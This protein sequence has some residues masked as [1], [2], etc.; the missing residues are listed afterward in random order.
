VATKLDFKGTKPKTSGRSLLAKS[1]N[2]VLN[3][4]VLRA[5]KG[6]NRTTLGGTKGTGHAKRARPLAP[7]ATYHIVLRSEKARGEYSML[8]KHHKSLISKLIYRQAKRF[9]VRVEGYANVG[10]HLH[11]K[12]YAQGD[13][14][15]QNFLRTITCLVARKVTGAT[16]AKKFGRFWDGLVFTRLIRTFTEHE[17]LKRYI[18]AN[19]LQADCGSKARQ[20]YL[21]LWYLPDKIKNTA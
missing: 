2:L 7:R 14:E 5:P 12:A 10:N 9:F 8:R 18:F 17:I 11:I 6:K 16:R 15:F 1:K 20:A 4:E 3:P 21:Q 13:K 19:I